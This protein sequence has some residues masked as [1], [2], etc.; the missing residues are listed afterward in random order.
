MSTLEELHERWSRDAD[1]RKAYERLKPEFE[2]ARALIEARQ[3]AGFTQA[4]LAARM[5]T[6]QSA[7]ARL[8]SGRIPPSTRTLEKVAKATGTRL[9]IGF[10]PV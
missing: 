1:Y 3:R 4:E 10:E 2:V 6:T 7:V 5:K 8:E 9:R